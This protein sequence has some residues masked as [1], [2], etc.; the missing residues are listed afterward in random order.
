MTTD[1]TTFDEFEDDQDEKLAKIES[2]EQVKCVCVN[3]FTVIVY[4]FSSYE[5][6]KLVLF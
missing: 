5:K 6:C 4:L 2:D 1:A 3:V